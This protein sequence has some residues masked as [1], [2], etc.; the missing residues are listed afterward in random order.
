MNSNTDLDVALSFTSEPS[1]LTVSEISDFSIHSQ[2]ENDTGTTSVPERAAQ[3]LDTNSEFYVNDYLT[4]KISGDGDSQI[5]TTHISDE[6]KSQVKKE[7]QD[8]ADIP[9]PTMLRRADTTPGAFHQPGIGSDR[10]AYPSTRDEEAPQDLSFAGEHLVSAT[11]VADQHT[12]EFVVAKPVSWQKRPSILLL[13]AVILLLT[14]T[15]GLS[16]GL[17]KRAD[18]DDEIDIAQES[19]SDVPSEFYNIS[20]FDRQASFVVAWGENST[21]AKS[22]ASPAVEIYCNGAAVLVIDDTQH[23]SCSRQ[24]STAMTCVLQKAALEATVIFS[25]GGNAEA[26]DLAAISLVSATVFNDCSSR[27]DHDDIG[28]AIFGGEA[29][30]YSS[31]GEFCRD[32]QN[33]NIWIIENSDRCGVNKKETFLDSHIQTEEDGTIR[34]VNQVYCYATKDCE[35]RRSCVDNLCQATGECT[36]LAVD[37]IQQD[38]STEITDPRCSFAPGAGPTLDVMRSVVGNR[39]GNRDDFLHRSSRDSKEL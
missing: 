26:H 36:N 29:I 28:F 19:F 12:G 27:L 14:L 8:A 17:T 20:S 1:A 5:K 35:D 38:I 9:I 18:E 32:Y 39:W 21:C 7:T 10:T 22:L 13:V 23:A 4:S 3:P 31:H 33:S 2:A 11:L 34:S 15:A 6:L 30:Q 16:T 24:S 25:C 37:T